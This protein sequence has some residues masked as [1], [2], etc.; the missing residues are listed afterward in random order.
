[1]SPW[2]RAMCYMLCSVS[3]ET[4]DSHDI[5]ITNCQSEEADQQLIRHTLQCISA[6][7]KKIVVRTVDTDV[8]ILL[9]SY[10]SHFYDLCTDVNIYIRMVNSA[11]QYYVIS[12]IVDLGKETCNALPIFYAFTGCDTVSS[13][14]S[15]RKCRAWEA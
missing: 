2:I 5:S 8:L 3:V 14:F 11:H 10:V 15:K 9:M 4:L 12:A 13:L 1:M 6:Q 7:Y